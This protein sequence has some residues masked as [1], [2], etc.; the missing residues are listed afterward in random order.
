MKRNTTNKTVNEIGTAYTYYL[1]NKI[2]QIWSMSENRE[3]S[4]E[5]MKKNIRHYIWNAAYKTADGTL[6]KK[7]WFIDTV[8]G[9]SSKK[10]IYWFCVNSINK[11]RE[12]V[13]R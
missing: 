6:T 11:A 13:A 8:N 2:K 1:E 5:D 10:D 3:V 9:M 12:T 4:I 7:Q